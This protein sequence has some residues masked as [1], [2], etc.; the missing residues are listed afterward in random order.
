MDITS[1][2]IDIS[3][4]SKQGRM[5]SPTGYL[6]YKSLKGKRFNLSKTNIMMFL[7]NP[8]LPV[9]IRPQKDK[10]VDIH[11]RYYLNS[12]DKYNIPLHISNL[13]ASLSTLSS[14]IS[15]LRN[16]ISED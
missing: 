6:P 13:K 9:F 2:S 5:M 8:R 16:L 11:I 12:N 4:N 15:P 3:I 14:R 1:H 7:T 10:L